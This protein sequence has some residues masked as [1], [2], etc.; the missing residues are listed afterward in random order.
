MP[1]ELPIKLL[2]VIL[3][4]R[5]ILMHHK[6][7]LSQCLMNPCQVCL[8]LMV[9][10]QWKHDDSRDTTN[11]YVSN[12]IRL[13]TLI[14]RMQYCLASRGAK[15]KRCFIIWHAQRKISI[16]VHACVYIPI[17]AAYDFTC[18]C[19]HIFFPA[20]DSVFIN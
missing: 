6:C 8:V 2:R 20:A 5:Y 9:W 17:L 18:W 16:L 15:N 11:R 10:Y 12:Q 1:H 3:F 13:D 19:R 4:S 7:I 14:S